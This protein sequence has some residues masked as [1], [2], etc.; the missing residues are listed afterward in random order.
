MGFT[1]VKSLGK[2][3]QPVVETFDED[4]VKSL[5]VSWTDDTKTK[6]NITANYDTKPI[7]TKL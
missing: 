5:T 4:S 6:C 2:I 1:S 3:L 7:E